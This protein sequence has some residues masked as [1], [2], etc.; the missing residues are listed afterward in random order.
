MLSH[1]CTVGKYYNFELKFNFTTGNFVDYTLHL[2]AILNKNNITEDAISEP[3][4][5]FGKCRHEILQIITNI[6][7][8]NKLIYC[9]W[10]QN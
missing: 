9:R 2:D 6:R 10:K 4:T 8:K 1:Y 3:Q 5:L 7:L